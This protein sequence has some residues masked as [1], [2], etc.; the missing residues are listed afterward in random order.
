MATYYPKNLL[1]SQR[2]AQELWQDISQAKI[3]FLS[4]ALGA[5]KTFFVK[6]LG[7][8]LRIKEE[9]ISPSFQLIKIYTIPN[10]KLSLVHTDLFRL[11]IKSPK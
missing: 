11:E 7:K 2:I 3:V 1:D 5:G 4:G 8:V 10:T 6:Q 9:I